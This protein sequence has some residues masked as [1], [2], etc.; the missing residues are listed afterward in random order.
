MNDG[1]LVDMHNVTIRKGGATLLKGV[2]LRICRG[3]RVAILGP[4]GS[5]KTSLIR[6]MVGELRHDTSV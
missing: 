3:E 6:A 2:D 4:N 1:P 5:G